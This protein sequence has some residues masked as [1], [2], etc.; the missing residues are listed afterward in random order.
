MLV[1]LYTADNI[2]SFWFSAFG[3]FFR[4]EIFVAGRKDIIKVISTD[5]ML[6]SPGETFAWFLDAENFTSSPWILSAKW[7]QKNRG[8][9]AV[10]GFLTLL[11]WYEERILEVQPKKCIRLEVLD[12]FPKQK[13]RHEFAFTE[14]M[15]GFTKVT[16]TVELIVPSAEIP[17][18]GDSITKQVRKLVKSYCCALLRSYRKRR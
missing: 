3:R 15:E 18:I 7:R 2:I 13:I 8:A 11:G 17:L 12:S 16:W 9:G 10:R 5:T 1:S 14:P 4:E 6:S